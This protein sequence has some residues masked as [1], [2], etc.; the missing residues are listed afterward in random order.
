[1]MLPT[2]ISVSVAPGS[3]FFCA[4]AV[5]APA[6]TSSAAKAIFFRFFFRFF[7]ASS[8]TRSCIIV[9]PDVLGRCDGSCSLLFGQLVEPS[10]RM[11][12][13]YARLGTCYQQALCCY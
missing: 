7:L 10:D 12:V 9:L 6:V 4:C 8:M 11:H 5:P 1:M 3:Y 2:L 13:Q